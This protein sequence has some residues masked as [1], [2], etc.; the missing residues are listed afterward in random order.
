MSSVPSVPRLPDRNVYN[1]LCKLRQSHLELLAKQAA[2]AVAAASAGK[3]G[4]QS[5]DSILARLKAL[6]DALA[7]VSGGLTL[8]M[9]AGESLEAYQVVRMADT[10]EVFVATDADMDDA[11]LSF[12]F[13]TAAASA[14]ATV[15]VRFAGPLQNSA[16]SLEMDEPVFLGTD[17]AITQTPPATGRYMEVGHAVGSDQI[18][19][20][21]RPVVVQVRGETVGAALIRTRADGVMDPSMAVIGQGGT[22]GIYTGAEGEAK[23]I[24]VEAGWSDE[25]G[26]DGDGWL[27]EI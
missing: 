14:G 11:S 25:F 3:A 18:L 15:Q 13:A 19:V 17:G 6:E 27:I 9:T 5:L 1:F 4:S 22:P 16:W 23:L 26:V 2:A 7:A 10:G 8:P 24:P 21:I 20:H 12:G